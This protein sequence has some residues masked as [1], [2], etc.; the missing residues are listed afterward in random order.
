MPPNHQTALPQPPTASN[1]SVL[2]AMYPP[3]NPPPST[4]LPA[5]HPPLECT[6][7]TCNRITQ[8]ENKGM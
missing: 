7:S 3:S 2:W 1:Q 4:G 6:N 8:Y 5:V